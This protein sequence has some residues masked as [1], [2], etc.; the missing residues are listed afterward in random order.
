RFMGMFLPATQVVLLAVIDKGGS[1]W[2][3]VKDG[4]DVHPMGSTNGTERGIF[5]DA[6][7]VPIWTPTGGYDGVL[8]TGESITASLPAIPNPPKPPSCMARRVNPPA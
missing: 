6:K 5:L 1:A 3:W 8:S 4:C 2:V 7:R